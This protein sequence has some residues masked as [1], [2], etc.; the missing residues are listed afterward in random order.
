MSPL[1]IAIIDYGLGNLY[2]V[3]QACE[4]LGFNPILVARRADLAS[5]AA[6]ILP[7]KTEGKRRRRRVLNGI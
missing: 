7:R 4:Q 5:A 1:H 3:R 6:V 2:S